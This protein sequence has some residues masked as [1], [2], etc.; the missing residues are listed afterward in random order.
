MISYV[1]ALML[2]VSLGILFVVVLVSVIGG[3]D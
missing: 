3:W 1:A 2:G